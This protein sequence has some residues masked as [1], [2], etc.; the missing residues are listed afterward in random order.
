MRIGAHAT[1]RATMRVGASSVQEM[2]MGAAGNAFGGLHLREQIFPKRWALGYM[3]FPLIARGSQEA[4]S[5]N[6]A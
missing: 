3:N 2:G 6:A 5:R 4:E 1:R